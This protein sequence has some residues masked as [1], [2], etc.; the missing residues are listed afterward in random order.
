RTVVTWRCKYK[1]AL[2]EQKTARKKEEII[3]AAVSVFM[4]KGYTGTT[5]EDVAA[6]LLMTK[7]SVYYYFKD[8]QELL[9]QSQKMLLEKSIENIEA[10]KQAQDLPVIERLRK[11]MI[12]H[13]KY[14]ISER[15]GFETMV[16]P[17]RY[18]AE[19][20][21]EKI[22]KLRNNYEKNFDQL[23]TE[24]IEGNVF[25]SLDIKIVRNIILG[26]MNWVIQ[27]YSPKGE[28]DESDIAELI[29]DYLL[30]ILMKNTNVDEEELYWK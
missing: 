23:I 21:V 8:K 10:I 13:L 18:F 3:Q 4:E 16:D 17:E 6:N 25:A 12:V 28:K 2:R 19:T 20:Q 27:W 7:G 14:L 5:M 1:V 24:G 26:A 30:R 15:S 11:S 22:I 29:S 9:Y